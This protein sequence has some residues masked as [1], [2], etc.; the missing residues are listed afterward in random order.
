ML[1]RTFAAKLDLDW[2]IKVHSDAKYASIASYLVGPL[3]QYFMH[4]LHF[5]VN[6]SLSFFIHMPF[7]FIDFCV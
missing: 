6:M 7:V 4:I 2:S 5:Q 1:L 3:K